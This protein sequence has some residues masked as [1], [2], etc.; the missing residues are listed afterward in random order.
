M[1]LSICEM[2][3]LVKEVCGEVNESCITSAAV[4]KIAPSE[5][6]PTAVFQQI[7][8]HGQRSITGQTAMQL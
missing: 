3:C 1:H 8:G 5:M 2:P 4:R 7:K 6:M